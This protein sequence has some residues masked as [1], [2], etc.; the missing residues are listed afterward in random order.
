M[1]DDQL[2]VVSSGAIDL[3]GEPRGGW[4]ALSVLDLE[5]P[6]SE[7]HSVAWRAEPLGSFLVE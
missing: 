2:A 6:L 5:Q 3:S 4:S 1:I 7:A